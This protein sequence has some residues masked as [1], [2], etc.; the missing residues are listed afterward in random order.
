MGVRAIINAAEPYRWQVDLPG[1]VQILVRELSNGRCEASVAGPRHVYWKRGD[2][3][4]EALQKL[5]TALRDLASDYLRL[6][7]IVR[8]VSPEDLPG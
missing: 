7:H 4:R 5:D 6:T 3:P 8:S 1:G 2:T